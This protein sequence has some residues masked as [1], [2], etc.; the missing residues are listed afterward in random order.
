[1]ID[2]LTIDFYVAVTQ[3]IITITSP[4]NVVIVG[5][6]ELT[7]PDTLRYKLAPLTEAGEYIVEWSVLPPD[8][9]RTASAYSFRYDPSVVTKKPPT[10][11][12]QPLA[13]LSAIGLSA[14]G[15]VGIVGIVGIVGAAAVWRRRS[16]KQ[17]NRLPT[18][19]SQPERP[20]S[21]P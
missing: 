3:P 10:N 19:P 20:S 18:A 6:A 2:H 21:A 14:I 16:R 9:H 13:L 4:S 12:Y 11:G 15:L 7:Q 1:M 8:G 5:T 17:T